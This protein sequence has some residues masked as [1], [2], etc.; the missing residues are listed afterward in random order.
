MKLYTMTACGRGVPL[1]ECAAMV[2]LFSAM[3][4]CLELMEGL[5]V[6]LHDGYE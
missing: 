4:L 6:I 2:V 5:V 1:E 3:C